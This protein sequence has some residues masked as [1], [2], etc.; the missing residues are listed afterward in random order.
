MQRTTS[1][2]N[3]D[4]ISNQRLTS[5]GGNAWSC[6]SRGFCI[7]IPFLHIRLLINVNIGRRKG[8]KAK[9][10]HAN[11]LLKDATVWTLAALLMYEIHR[12][13]YVFWIQS[14]LSCCASMLSCFAVIN[15]TNPCGD[16]SIIPY[17]YV[18]ADLL[19]LSIITQDDVKSALDCSTMYANIIIAKTFPGL[20][21]WPALG[22]L[23]GSTF[24][25]DVE[26]SPKVDP[27]TLTGLS[28]GNLSA[29][30]GNISISGAGGITS[31]KFPVL[32]RIGGPELSGEYYQT[33]PWKASSSPI[34]QAS[35]SSTRYKD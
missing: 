31:L 18:A 26:D 11:V 22:N 19:N 6:P 2:T 16:A 35:K 5:D 10:R 25:R 15:A 34:C 14:I 23:Y 28:F 29:L 17:D 20:V 27:S 30:R 4:T 9:R 12:C 1:Q 7:H 33:S 8:E 13:K 32:G 21:N 3:H 24:V